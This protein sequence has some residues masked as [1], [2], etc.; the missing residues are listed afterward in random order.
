[1]VALGIRSSLFAHEI[2]VDAILEIHG[3][4]ESHI[5]MERRESSRGMP[6]SSISSEW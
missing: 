5:G 4:E 6:L 1:M 2:L 3:D